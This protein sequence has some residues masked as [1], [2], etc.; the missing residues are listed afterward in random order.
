[1]ER[2][3]LPCNRLLKEVIQHSKFVKTHNFEDLRRSLETE[4]E[5]DGSRIPYKFT[6]V[7]KY[8]QFVVLAYMPK[9]EMV[10]EFIKIKPRGYF[11]H[12]QYHY[13]FQNMINWFKQEFRSRDYQRFV[14]KTGSP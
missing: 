1:M 6:V 8:P 9:K 11:F 10:K 13:P 4:K 2:Y 5:E 14:R 12:Q 3:I 7:D